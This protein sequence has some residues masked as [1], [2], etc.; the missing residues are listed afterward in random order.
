MTRDQYPAINQLVLDL[1]MYALPLATI[2]AFALLIIF[3]RRDMA[4]MQKTGPE[5][6]KQQSAE[7]AACIKS[8][9]ELEALI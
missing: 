4:R 9:K 2:L 1:L 5:K 3:M 8:Y 6:Q 7:L